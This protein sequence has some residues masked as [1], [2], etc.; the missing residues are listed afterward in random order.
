[1]GRL[2]KYKTNVAPRLKEIQKWCGIYNEAQIAKKL[3]VGKTS[4]EKYKNEH[5]ELREALQAGK[6]TL[7]E[8]LKESLRRKAMGFEYEETKTTIREAAG[9]KTQVIEI[10]EKYSP[11]DTGAIHL[12]LK[13][14]DD[15][16]RNDDRATLDLKREKME[17]ER[18]KSLESW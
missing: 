12:L 6:E 8:E 16:W 11:P 7:I 17:L 10:M 1:M 3:G 15:S 9:V 13:N 18:E 14:L 4:F 2:D 5:S